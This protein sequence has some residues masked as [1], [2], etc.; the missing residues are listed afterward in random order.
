MVA[1]PSGLGLAKL[2]AEIRVH[3][4]LSFYQHS[5]TLGMQF[6]ET[7]EHWRTD[8]ISIRFL[9]PKSRGAAV[10]MHNR[11]AF[12]VDLP[13][14]YQNFVSRFRPLALGYLKLP[15]IKKVLRGGIRGQYFITQGF[16]FEE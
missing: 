2:S 5:V 3:P 14:D 1:I 12:E 11:L 8:G 7:F 15:H 4:T 10:I 6:E 9:D 16:A 13:G